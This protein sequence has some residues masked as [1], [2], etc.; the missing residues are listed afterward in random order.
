MC[1]NQFTFVNVAIR[2]FVNWDERGA[3]GIE[4]IPFLTL[5]AQYNNVT[6]FRN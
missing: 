1:V 5:K 4:L 2:V 3:C 6:H